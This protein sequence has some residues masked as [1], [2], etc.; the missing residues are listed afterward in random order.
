MRISPSPPSLRLILPLLKGFPQGLLYGP[1]NFGLYRFSEIG[2]ESLK[3]FVLVAFSIYYNISQS[4][5]DFM[6]GIEWGAHI[7][8]FRFDK[9]FVILFWGWVPSFIL[10]STDASRSLSVRTSVKGGVQPHTRDTYFWLSCYHPMEYG[11]EVTLRGSQV[12]LCD[13]S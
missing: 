2:C 10:R 5:L 12:E 4:K 7:G 3:H 11:F 6:T 13:T 8:G 1:D 9:C